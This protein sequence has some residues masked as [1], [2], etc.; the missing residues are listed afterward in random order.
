[1]P[2]FKKI[3]P[4]LIFGITLAIVFWKIEPPKSFTQA[5]PFQITVFFIPLLFFIICL[6]NL[7]FKFLLKSSV[8]GI[9]LLSIILLQ[10]FGILNWIVLI[11]IL[12]FIFV[13]V[14]VIKKP[15]AKRKKA[16]KLDTTPA[17]LPSILKP[18]EK[19]PD[20]PKLKRLR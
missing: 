5:S 11:A 18:L 3:L 10:A 7:Y 14:K 9:G 4:I 1:M 6:V 8:V 19:L 12:F 13:L 16:R 15:E 17:P 20:L 2:I